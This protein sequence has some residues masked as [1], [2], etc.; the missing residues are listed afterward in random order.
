M[1][2]RKK[3]YADYINNIYSNIND[4]SPVGFEKVAK[5]YG[6][7]LKFLPEE[8]TSHILDCGSGPGYFLYFLKKHG[9]KNTQGIDCSDQAVKI[10]ESMGLNVRHHDIFGFL[11]ECQKEHFGLIMFFDVLEHLT[12]NEVLE[13]LALANSR[14][15]PGGKVLI[16][17]PNANSPF[18]PR[19]RWKDFTH[20]LYFTEETLVQ[21]LLACGANSHVNAP[22]FADIQIQEDKSVI[23]SFICAVRKTFWFIAKW[24]YKAFMILGIGREA[25]GIPLEYKIIGI[26]K[27]PNG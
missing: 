25:I 27:K 20:E 7:Y 26:G 21:I 19:L 11:K 18:A 24:L 3:L 2:Y 13:V 14:L 15:I 8:K 1:E 12:K 6:N 4:L 5:S 17:V 10:A 23:T 22:G 9:Y 16:S